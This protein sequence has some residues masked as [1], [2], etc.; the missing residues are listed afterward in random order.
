ML[1]G[2]M[3]QETQSMVSRAVVNGWDQGDWLLLVVS[4]HQRLIG[5]HIKK[6][7]GV[8]VGVGGRGRQR[9]A[10][11]GNNNNNNREATSKKNYEGL[12]GNRT[13]ASRTLSENFTT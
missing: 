13:R 10:R 7:G 8:G 9:G 5:G 11:R 12:A 2:T 4:D 6:E 1:I 3:K